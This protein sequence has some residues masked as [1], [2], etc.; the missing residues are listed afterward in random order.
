MNT[1]ES[2]TI[3]IFSLILTVSGFNVITAV[4]FLYR[5]FKTNTSL[6]FHI[7][8]SIISIAGVIGTS[9]LC[10]II[11]LKYKRVQTTFSNHYLE[12]LSNF[13][14]VYYELIQ[15]D[16]E[17]KKTDSCKYKCKN[18]SKT[19]R[20]S[21]VKMLDSVCSIFEDITRKKICACI[22]IIS[23]SN[24]QEP[25]VY[26][27]ARSKNTSNDRQENDKNAFRLLRE[28]TDF[29]VLSYGP[30]Q[31]FYSRSLKKTDKRLLKKRGVHYCNNSPNYGQE[32]KYYKSTIVVPIKYQQSFNTGEYIVH[33]DNSSVLGFLCIDSISERAFGES[34]DISDRN[35]KL[36]KSFA[37]CFF[38]LLDIYNFY[39]KKYE[40]ESIGA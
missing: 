12:F 21:T 37:T 7:I 8:I 4:S 2:K 31:F 38:V 20:T 6:V 33:L 22:K 39:L 9:I 32:Y 40:K 13:R 24:D 3:S 14:N 1:K 25:L 18:M 10:I 15:E 36:L 27:L 11:L 28:N 30:D 17:F 16:N 5:I 34:K 35:I 26:T 19:M 23:F 29:N